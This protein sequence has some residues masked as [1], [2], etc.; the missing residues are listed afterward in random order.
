MT[1]CLSQLTQT[2]IFQ[3]IDPKTATTQD[4][5]EAIGFITTGLFGRPIETHYAAVM[6]GMIRREAAMEKYS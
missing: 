4:V 3:G 5:S 6:A 1:P 2:L